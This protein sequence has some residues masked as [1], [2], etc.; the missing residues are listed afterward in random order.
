[1][2]WVESRVERV[3]LGCSQAEQQVEPRSAELLERWCGAARA[4]PA[5][6]TLV[7]V[8]HPDDDVL[9]LGARLRFVREQVDIVYV[10][11]GAPEPPAFYRPLGFETREQYAEGRR[12]EARRALRLAGVPEGHV[13]ELGVVDQRA[14]HDI[15]RVARAIVELVRLLSPDALLTH[16]Y[17][18]GHPDHD[19][20]ACAAHAACGLLDL[21]RGRVPALLEFASY[22]A[23]GNELVRGEFSPGSGPS[24]IRLELDAQARQFKRALLRCHASQE[25]VWQAFPLSHELFRVAPRY[26]FSQPPAAPF[27]YDRVDWGV[28][29]SEF[30]SRASQALGA[31]GVEVLC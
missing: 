3:D 14:A 12:R 7:I 17:E 15:Q 18:G 23:S 2:L 22:Y 19:A 9:G 29:G 24:A 6:R 25:P 16:A 4:R 30:S 21:Q 31:L 26:D 28:S 11:D 13:H 5:P 27:H 10:T 20:T 1:V 8:A